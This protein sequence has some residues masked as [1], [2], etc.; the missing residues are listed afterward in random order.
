MAVN[1]MRNKGILLSKICNY[2]SFRRPVPLRKLN[3]TGFLWN[4]TKPG[5]THKPN[6]LEKYLLVWMKKYP[7]VADVPKYV[8][9]EVMEKV[10][11]KSRIKINIVFCFITAAVCVIMIF[12]GKRAAERGESVR[13]M[14]I[15]WHEEQNAKK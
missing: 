1:L 11:N 10:R 4:S 12:S 7:S 3:T 9:P 14:N 13:K 5:A 15:Q 2:E 8:T 6:L